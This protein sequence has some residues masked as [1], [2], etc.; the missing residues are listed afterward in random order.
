MFGITCDGVVFGIIYD[1][2]VFGIIYD[3]DVFGII[4]DG[5]DHLVSC[6]EFF[7]MVY[8]LGFMGSQL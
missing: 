7:T 6:S 3:G 8:N 4:Y 1:G 2:I 5:H